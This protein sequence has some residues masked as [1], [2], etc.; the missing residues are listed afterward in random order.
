M[1]LA[2]EGTSFSKAGYTFPKPLIDINGKPMV[3]AVAENIRPTHPSRFIFI[4][5]REHYDT[6]SLHEVFSN[7]SKKNFE[8]IKLVA[9]TKG[10]A[11]AVLSAIDFINN[12]DELMIANADQLIDV[13]VDDFIEFARNSQADGVIMT[14]ESSHPRWSFVRTNTNGQ[15]IEVA[16]KKAISNQA[17]VGIYYFREG[18]QF[19]NYSLSMI[20]KNITV[21][22]QFYVCPV[23]NE[24]ILDD[25]IIQTWHISRQSMHGLGTP[26]DFERYLKNSA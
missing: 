19:V 12:D 4:C 3:Q 23:Y 1:P 25:K 15:V 6:Y 9:P 26:E 17:T 5:K 21:N 7:A 16:E 10:A 24:M 22:D 20:Q 11:C 14:F 13:P 8:T 18:R 2:G